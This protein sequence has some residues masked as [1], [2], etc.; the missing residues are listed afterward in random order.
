LIHYKF[1]EKSIMN[2]KIIAAAVAATMTSVAFA[3]VSI[4]GQMKANYKNTDLGNGTTIGN[5]ISTEANL[6][7]TGKS[8]DTTVYFELDADSAD[9]VTSDNFDIEDQW[10]STK[11]GDITAKVGTWNGGDTILDADST[12]TIGKYEL[13]TSVGGLDLTFDGNGG[14]ADTN[15]KLATKV[16]DVA[17]SAKMK[18]AA[19]QYTLNTSIAGVD[20]SYALDAE[21]AAN[22]DESSLVVGTTV[23]G[24]RV[25]YAQAEADTGAT[26]D[27]DSWFGDAA[28]LYVN[29]TTAGLAAGDDI[30]G[31]KFKSD[32]AGNTV[33]AVFFSV[34]DAPSGQN[35][36]DNTKLVVTRPLAGGTTLEVIYL[37][38]DASASA[39]DY[40]MI[41]VELAVKF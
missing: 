22:S 31:I 33:Q 25:E 10:M 2:K 40:E 24:V 15:L 3:D 26:I 27:G 14:N 30:S 19:E 29:S 35:D 17:V 12:R 9:G 16:G 28:A 4:T 18:N 34:D 5:N 6:Y 38:T 36:V 32:V 39:N 37:S 20:I 1:M 21:D 8:G 7:I 41:D 23:G 11:I 13:K